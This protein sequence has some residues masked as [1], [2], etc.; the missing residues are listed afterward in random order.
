M[1]KMYSKEELQNRINDEIVRRSAGLR[2]RKPGELY[3]PIDYSLDV[4]GKRLRPVLLLMAYN[5]FSEEIEKALP[6]ALAIEVF[7]NFTLLHDDIM[8]KAEVRRNMPTVHLQFSENSA[9]LSGDAMAFLSYQYLLECRSGRM[10]EVASLFTKTALEVCEGQQYDMD[11][12]HRL[13]VTEAEYLEM[14]KLKTAVLLGCSLQAGALLANAED[15]T[16]QQLYD[17]GINLGM[18]FQLQ[19]D[20]LDTFGDQKKF[21]KKIGG[22]IVTNKKTYLLITALEKASEENKKILDNWLNS[23]D[24]DA[25]EKVASVTGIYNQLGIKELVESKIESYFS[26][27]EKILAHL[28]VNELNKKFLIEL[29]ESML[30]RRS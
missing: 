12:E 27:A 10:F 7:H 5:L 9:I 1:D 23:T 22:D 11:F 14:I 25:V 16:A 13:D 26:E 30:G 19:D 29:M 15:E 2:A 28:P 20:W 6:A 8:D 18:A 4:G 3:A 24:F 21:G 17:F